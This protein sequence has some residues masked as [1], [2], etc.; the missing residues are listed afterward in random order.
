VA[1][2]RIP[3]SRVDDGDGVGGIVG[4]AMACRQ[5]AKAQVRAGEGSMARS[6]L[7]VNAAVGL[8]AQRTVLFNDTALGG[9]PK[10]LIAELPLDQVASVEL[11][12]K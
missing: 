12:K 11:E 4:R 1:T 7:T 2:V 8:T 3:A 6:W 5:A 10:D 9:K